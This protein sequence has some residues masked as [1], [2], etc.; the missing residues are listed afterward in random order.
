MQSS[1]EAFS[2]ELCTQFCF[3]TFLNEVQV[4][5][6][7]AISISIESGAFRNST[8][9]STWGA[10]IEMDAGTSSI[11][12]SSR[13]RGTMRPVTFAR[14]YDAAKEG[15]RLGDQR[16]WLHSNGSFNFTAPYCVLTM[17]RSRIASRGAVT[18]KIPICKC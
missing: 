1:S 14:L 3:H 12:R 7:V 18:C 6:G 11:V 17:A 8:A 16:V 5:Q 13:S 4:T 9:K 15:G 10:K 2:L